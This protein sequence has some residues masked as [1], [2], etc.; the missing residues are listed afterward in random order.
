MT[1]TLQDSSRKK[2]NLFWICYLLGIPLW[3]YLNKLLFGS[4]NLVKPPFCIAHIFCLFTLGINL[5]LQL[6]ERTYAPISYDLEEKIYEYVERNTYYLIMAI[7]IFLLISSSGETG[8]FKATNINFRL[9]V[10]SQA[11]AIGF[12]IFIIALYWM[13][14]KKGQEGWLAHLRHI[15]T[16]FLTYALSLFFL[17]PVELFIKL[18]TTF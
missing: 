13:P 4:V 7:T 17:G 16:I 14:T 10:Y 11:I 5:L 2:Q 12:C 15:K 6:I 18:R 3:L 9:I 8:I 1:S